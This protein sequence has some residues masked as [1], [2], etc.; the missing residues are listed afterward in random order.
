MDGEGIRSWLLLLVA[1][2]GF[3]WIFAR[4]GWRCDCWLIAER[5]GSVVSWGILE[6]RSKAR[7]AG[8]E[9]AKKFE[10][11]TELDGRG[12]AGSPVKELP[13]SLPRDFLAKMVEMQRRCMEQMGRDVSAD[14]HVK[15]VV[16]TPF[17]CQHALSR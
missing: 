7:E 13:V 12:F 15:S 10:L 11:R 16:R 6:M 14:A 5:V 2:A 8:A 9:A 4:C 3:D 17:T 1:V